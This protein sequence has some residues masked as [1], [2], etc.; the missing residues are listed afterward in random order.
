MDNDSGIKK[1]TFINVTV[2]IIL[3]SL[4]IISGTVFY[5]PALVADGVHSLS[6]LGTDVI[7][8]FS[9]KFSVKP[10]DKNHPY[11]HGKIESIANLL[12]AFVLI[13][14]AVNISISSYKSL[15]TNQVI[16]PN[17]LNLI[18]AVISI[19]AKEILYHINMG[20]SK[21]INNETLVTNA[22][23]H[24]TDAVSS[25]AVLTGIVLGFIDIRLA[26]ADPIV[27]FG[28]SI[29]IIYVGGKIL[30]QAVNKII[31][32]NID[33][34]LEEEIKNLVLGKKEVVSL[35]DLRGRYYGGNIIID[36]HI[37]LDPEITLMDA[38]NITH[39]VKEL[40]KRNYPLI[41]D[42]VIHTEP[43][44]KEV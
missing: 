27:S 20:F 15:I 21:K 36:L 6:D 12:I 14:A 39:E 31:D 1:V 7:V 32:R 28:I 11:G 44:E 38:H 10:K 4:K 37:Q 29:L 33:R 3:S 8:L 24:R 34:E 35:H 17:I 5:S 2:N 19:A 43:A 22:W 9:F 18:V 41:I 42:A 26:I 40:I 16:Y 25:F 13:F 23:H 30:F